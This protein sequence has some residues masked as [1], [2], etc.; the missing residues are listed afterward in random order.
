MAAARATIRL[1]NEGRITLQNVKADSGA[2]L[3]AATLKRRDYG[4]CRRR[5]GAD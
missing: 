4:R 2:V 3:V 5:G 1:K